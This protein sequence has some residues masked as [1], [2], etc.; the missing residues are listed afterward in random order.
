MGALDGAKDIGVLVGRLDGLVLAVGAV[1][2]AMD[3]GRHVLSAQN[4]GPSEE[5]GVV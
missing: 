1:V 5:E 4:E 2:S 3:V